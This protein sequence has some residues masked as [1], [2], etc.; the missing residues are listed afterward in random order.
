M[1][2]YFIA[3]VLPENLN[4]EIKVFKNVMAEKWGCKVA[5]KSPAHITLVPP[6][7][8]EQ[9]MEESLLRHLDELGETIAPFSIATN[10]FAAFKPRTIFIQPVLNEALKHMKKKTDVFCKTHPDYG[11]RADTR[12]FHPHITIAT[13]DLDKKAFAE[14]WPYFEKQSYNITFDATGISTLRHNSK[15]WDVLHTSPFAGQ[16]TP[17]GS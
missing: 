5:L 13:R 16:N 10:H 14:A 17:L 9:G 8:M 7:R 15:D 2:L 11:A 4:E 6:F 3:I 1:R 12:P